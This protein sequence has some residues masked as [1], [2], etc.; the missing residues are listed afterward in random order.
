MAVT[1]SKYTRCICCKLSFFCLDICTFSKFNTKCICDIF[2]CSKKSCGNKNKLTR[3]FLLCSLYRNHHS[4]SSFLVNFGLEAYN[5][6][7]LKI[8]F[9]IF[10]EFFYCCCINSW[11]M[12]KYRYCLFLTVISLAYKRPLWP[13]ITLSSCIRCLRHHLKLCN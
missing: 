1:G 7:L 10:L 9:F 12:S 3:K 6:N 2:L 4:S 8:S 13:W 11:I 5:N